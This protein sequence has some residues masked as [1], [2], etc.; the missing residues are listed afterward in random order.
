MLND[1][2]GGTSS[3][4]ATEVAQVEKDQKI[5]IG[6]PKKKKTKPIAD[7]MEI[8]RPM[9]KNPYTKQMKAFLKEKNVPLTIAKKFYIAY[10]EEY[11]FLRRIKGA[12]RP[13]GVKNAVLFPVLMKREDKIICPGAQVRPLDAG[14]D[15]LKYYTVFPFKSNRFFF[16]EHLL[17][18]ARRKKIFLVEGSLD[19]MHIWSQKHV[20]FAL[21]GLYISE[22]R[23]KKIRTAAPRKVY[24]LLDPDQN[25]AETPFKVQESLAREGVEAEILGSEV[26]PK[27][28]SKGDLDNF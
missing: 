13:I 19:A 5:I 17:P 2:C 21:F 25:E 22:E 7:Y 8:L 27:Q 24:I 4:I 15:D 9:L 18:L 23:A 12:D 6:P 3:A 1:L 16:G 28:L 14:P 20:A 26:D 10:V 11:E